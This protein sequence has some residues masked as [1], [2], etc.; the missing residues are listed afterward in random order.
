[1]LVQL[2]TALQVQVII[3]DLRG[4]SQLFHI[5]LIGH[6]VLGCLR[7]VLLSDHPAVGL[8]LL[9]V[10]GVAALPDPVEHLLVV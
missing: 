7:V 1:M 10:Y 6:T 3:L 8:R 4:R 9:N 5:R 2:I